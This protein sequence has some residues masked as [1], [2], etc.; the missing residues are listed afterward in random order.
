MS[1]PY[2]GSAVS[3]QPFDKLRTGVQLPASPINHRYAESAEGFHIM[4]QGPLRLSGES[5][6]GLGADG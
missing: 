2:P 6:V 5:W 3:Y 1:H 4:S